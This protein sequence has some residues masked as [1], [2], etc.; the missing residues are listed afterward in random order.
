MPAEQPEH[1]VRNKYE[2]D[3]WQLESTAEE[4]EGLTWNFRAAVEEK[5]A[6]FG[7]DED[8]AYRFASAAKEGVENAI[9]HGNL[10]M[11]S[12]KRFIG[13]YMGEMKQREVDP[14]NQMK[15]VMLHWGFNQATGEVSL[16]IVDEG[17]GF[18]LGQLPE[19]ITLEDVR[20]IGMRGIFLMRNFLG[21]ENVLFEKNEEGKNEVR[22]LAHLPYAHG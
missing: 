20:T 16:A 7:F 9:I 2:G 18:D 15:K 3:T 10:G 12:E 5:L 21:K 22:L 4:A 17:P 11:P 14:E 1:T 19:S 6:S 13:N 8:L